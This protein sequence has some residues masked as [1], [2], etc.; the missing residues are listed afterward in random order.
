M[1]KT[2]RFPGRKTGAPCPSSPSSFSPACCAWPSSWRWHC[3]RSER[4]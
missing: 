3:S 2:G 1:G 4:S